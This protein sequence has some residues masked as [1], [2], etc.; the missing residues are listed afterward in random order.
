[1]EWWRGRGAPGRAVPQLQYENRR[2]R[3]VVCGTYNQLIL[4][5]MD[6]WRLHL[7]GWKGRHSPG[8]A[9]PPFGRWRTR[10]VYVIQSADSTT[11]GGVEGKGCAGNSSATTMGGGEQEKFLVI[12]SADST[13]GGV[14]EGKGCAG[15]SS[16][17][18]MEAANMRSLR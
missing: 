18:T 15:N 7:S 3:E 4:L 6:W 9:A 10:E 14:V 17:T 12:I 1:M 16:A 11:G 8:T 2:S 13:T 5:Q